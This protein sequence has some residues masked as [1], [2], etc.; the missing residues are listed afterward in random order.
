MRIHATVPGR[1][2]SMP[3]VRVHHSRRMEATT[4]RGLPVTTVPRTLLDLASVLPYTQLRRALA[5]AD[6]RRLLAAADVEAVLGRGRHGSAAL[7]KAFDE[8]LPELAA[9]RSMLEERFLSLCEQ[10]ELPLPEVNSIVCGLEVDAVWR[11]QRVIAELD[12][13]RAHALIAATERDRQRELTLRSAAYRVLRYTWRQVTRYPEEVSAD[14]RSALRI[15]E[16]RS[17]SYP[18]ASM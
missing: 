18:A 14:L 10:A 5:E 4:H 15:S 3:A 6:Y 11:E 17:S 16:E 7:R 12:G 13:H 9:T 8:H 1:R 2:L